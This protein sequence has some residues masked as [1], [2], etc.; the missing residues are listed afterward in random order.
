MSCAYV[1]LAHKAP[2]QVARLIGR[3]VPAPV[4]LHVDSA[5]NAALMGEFRSEVESASDVTFVP[6]HRSGWASWGIVAAALEGMNSALARPGWSHLALISGQD[7]PLVASRGIDAFLDHHPSTSFMPRWPLPT[8]LWGAD[9]GMHRLRYRHFPRRGHRLFIPLR[10][11]LPEG[12]RFYGG[13]LYWVLTR[14]AVAD[15]LALVNERPDLVRFYRR[16][17]IPD[18]MFIPTAVL[19]S[20]SRATV[21]SENLTYIRWRSREAPHP[22]TL[23]V[24]DVPTLL[25]ASRG[26]CEEGA[27]GRRKVFARKFDGAATGT[28]VFDRLDEAALASDSAL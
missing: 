25:A 16:T 10:R 27:R 24:E 14:G 11:K 28:E 12:I 17:W 20:P 13:S 19:N 22:D 23:G 9:G 3:L 26:L 8:R 1:V 4:F 15:V 5:V 18:E 6:R 2:S 21:V 7:Y